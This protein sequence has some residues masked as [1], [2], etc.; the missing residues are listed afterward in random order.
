VDVSFR[1]KFVDRETLSAQAWTLEQ[2]VLDTFGRVSDT[3]LRIFMDQPQ[4]HRRVL[5]GRRTPLR[6]TDPEIM[7]SDLTDE[8]RSIVSRAC[9]AKE[10]FLIEGPPG[11][12]KTSAVLRAIVAHCCTHAHERVL[13]VAFTNRA[14]NEISSVLLRHGVPHLRHGSVEGA[15]GDLSIPH[16]GHH[17]TAEDLAERIAHTPVIVSTV[18]SLYSSPEIWQFGSFTTAVIDEASQILEPP[19]LGIMSRVGRS[20]LIGD[21]CQ[22]PA[23]VTQP[24]AMLTVSVPALEAI[25][26]TSL[27]MS[28]F[29]RL[30]AMAEKRSDASCV[31]MLTRQGRMHADIMEVASQAFYG[32][33]LRVLR[34]DQ[35]DPSPLPWHNVV[36][37][38]VG[39]LSVHAAGRQAEAEASVLVDLAMRIHSAGR[40]A[41]RPPSIGII[42]PFRVQNTAIIGMLPEEIRDEITVDTVERFQGSERDVILYGTAVESEADLQ[43]IISEAVVHG[44]TVD[45]KLNVAVTRAREQFILVGNTGILA[46]RASYARVLGMMPTIGYR[47]DT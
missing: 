40:A 22:L 33:H 41:E 3:A 4:D 5:L 20:I 27:G 12:G 23:V 13:A 28:G 26:L 21:V 37:E 32:G 44:R 39:V 34:S 1:N 35:A 38:R 2:D 10:L 46:K 24:P 9:G 36:S 30:I 11:T 43:G 16:L 19:L 14:A 31:A 29:E 18:Q 8:Q 47:Q 42:T 6:G 17:L 15:I 7:A 45:R 25:G